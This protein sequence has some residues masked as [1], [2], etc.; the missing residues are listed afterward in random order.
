METTTEE[1][2]TA[3][4]KTEEAAEIVTEIETETAAKRVTVRVEKEKDPGVEK[5]QSLKIM[6]NA[7]MNHR[8]KIKEN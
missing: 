4:I 2:T 3:R 1:E 7:M 6:M 8:L 5:E